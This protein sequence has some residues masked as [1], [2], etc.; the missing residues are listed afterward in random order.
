[1]IP[2]YVAK[3]LS[4]ISSFECHFLSV[5]M[6]GEGS[7]ASWNFNYERGLVDILHLHKHPRFR[8]QNGWTT[9]GWKSIVKNFN[10]KFPLAGFSK[11]QIQ[12]KEK[13]LK[14]NFKA[15]RD[16]KKKS[17][18]GWN[19]TLGMINTT[20]EIWKE[21]ISVRILT[22]PLLILCLLLGSM[23]LT[24]F[25]LAF[26]RKFQSLRNFKA[27]HFRYLRAWKNYIMVIF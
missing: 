7:R 25:L 26:N 18:L 16:G 5:A 11:A 21:L 17:G 2:V 9:E 24:I 1:M 15:L 23:S 6:T 19:G 10:E 3:L 8:G 14:G 13:E 27:N 12:E 20:P 22:L 4:T